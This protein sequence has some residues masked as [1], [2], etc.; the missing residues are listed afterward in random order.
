M[1]FK[2][3]DV[4]DYDHVNY[5]KNGA[6]HH[7]NVQI[8]SGTR[9]IIAHCD[10]GPIMGMILFDNW[11]YNAVFGH[12]VVD[13]VMCLKMGGLMTEA[14]DFVFN[15][16]G[17]QYFMGAVPA[18]KTKALAYEKRAGFKEV[19]RLKDGFKLGID[20]IFVQMTRESAVFLPKEKRAA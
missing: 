9:G 18:D 2:A 11:S 7:G 8:S 13:N 3:F 17:L 15:T 14:T 19:Y 5:F 16:C 6:L 1:I 10:S 20:L 4:L 12:I